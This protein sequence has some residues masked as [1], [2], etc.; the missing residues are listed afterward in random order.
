MGCGSSNDASKE[1]I[2][3]TQLKD[4]KFSHQNLIQENKGNVKKDYQ[5]I[6]P[7]LGKGINLNFDFINIGA[8][9]EVYK[10]KHRIS[11]QLRAIKF[12][13]KKAMSP[14]QQK[15]LVSEVE[16]LKQLDHPN[17]IA[18]Y[19][20]YQDE[21]FFYI[22]TELCSGGELFDRIV[23]EKHFSEKKAARVMKQ[24]LSAVTYCHERNIVHR[25]LKPENILCDTNSAETQLKVADFGTGQ[26]FDPTKKMSERVGTPY[27]IAPEVLDSKYTEKC[28]IWS[29]GV[30]LY[31]M[32]C[33]YPP[34]NGEDDYQVIA[35]VR[36][37]RVRFPDPE[38]APVS[39]QAK[40]FI[41]NLLEMDSK[42]RMS[43]T[44]ALNDQWIQQFN[45]QSAMDVPL[46]AA[47]LEKLKNFR[48]EKKLQEA[49]LLFMVNFLST[50]ED[51]KELLQQF[52]QLDLN[53][54]GKLSREELLIGYKKVL[55]DVEAEQQVDD[56]MQ[57]L[58]KDQSG[59]IDYSEFALAMI[60]MEKLLATERL[61]KAFKLIDKDQSGYINKEEI[62]IAFGSNAGI[63]EDVWKEMIKEVDEN[64]DGQIS[65]DEFSSMMLKIIKK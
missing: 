62:K 24:L 17:I 55:T 21:Q 35:A 57:K 58:D 56:I 53:N 65:F 54:D 44:E 18:V 47:S 30:I 49:A 19:E 34:F 40:Q 2:K 1:T 16:I 60:D 32:L 28:D 36:K 50:K 33:G 31:I 52:Q 14:D 29:C 15:K 43:A 25:D 8:F 42:K 6:Y 37:G 61:V 64:S 26:I 3:V 63:H 4:T 48:I 41:S 45:T 38:W 11:E 59:S 39:A 12:I 9:G 10:A 5:L 13:K 7:P 27:Y 20:F 23:Q 22:V 46:M 51:K